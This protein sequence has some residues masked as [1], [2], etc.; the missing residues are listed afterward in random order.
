MIHRI[1]KMAFR[2]GEV[3]N[4]LEIFKKNCTAIRNFPG[5][6]SL[7]LQRGI[8]S[9]IL[10]TYSL[11]ESDDSLQDYRESRLFRNIWNQTKVLF[12]DKPEAWSTEVIHRLR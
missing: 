7:Q 6:E 9:S 1:V 5:C 3:D 12:K 2:E 11:W 4:F 8:G 10:F